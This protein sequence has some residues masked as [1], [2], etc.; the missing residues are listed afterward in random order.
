MNDPRIC[1]DAELLVGYLYGEGNE[2]DRVRV[3]A[4]LATCAACREE[5]DGLRET[6]THLASWSSPGDIIDVRVPRAA[7][8][9]RL[10]ARPL[11]VRW[12]LAA[13]AMLILGA[14]AAI[15]NLDV[16]LDRDGVV[17]RAGWRSTSPESVPTDPALEEPWRA[18]LAATERRLRGEIAS[19]QVRDAPVEQPTAET[20]TSADVMR[21]IRSVVSESEARQQRELALRMAQLS[22][23]LDL[24]RR[25]D[26]VRIGRGL[27]QLE[28]A[29]GAEAARQRDLL[30][31][32]VRVAQRR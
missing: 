9:A 31:Y 6:R 1:E 30:N 28:G 18:A 23:E 32:L 19:R 20:L 3:E 2:H 16:T 8:Q 21:R 17:I 24:Q 26:M 7:W 10:M 11:V 29:N 4:H 5:L 12:G 15:A 25:S 27:G 13:A 22:S 14:S